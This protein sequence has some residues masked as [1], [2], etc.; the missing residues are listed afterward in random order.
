M[1]FNSYLIVWLLPILLV[2]AS[3]SLFGEL[4]EGFDLSGKANTSFG[5][6]NMLGGE[7]S[8]GWMSSW[9]LGDGN[10]VF[11]K[12]D[13]NFENLPSTGGSAKV[14]G[15]RKEN[16]IGKGYM[17]RQLSEGFVGTV[18]G[19]FRVKPGFLTKDSVWAL[20]FIA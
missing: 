11:S 7:T 13:I 18:L 17:I 6:K 9:Q 8:I 1:K 20:I 4:Y 19:S 16:H 3:G 14:I 10:V 5:S 2:T 12:E 15:E